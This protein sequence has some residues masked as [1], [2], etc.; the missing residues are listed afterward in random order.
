MSHLGCTFGV[1]K[2]KKVFLQLCTAWHV[3]RRLRQPL[4][5][6]Y[7]TNSR[8]QRLQENRKVPRPR[9]WP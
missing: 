2:A 1:K 8:V 9:G 6:N 7:S 3:V 5:L 4:G